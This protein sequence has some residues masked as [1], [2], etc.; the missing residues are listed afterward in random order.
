LSHIKTT[1]NLDD[2]L[3][4]R[5]K[6]LA[7]ERGTT[8]TAVVEAALRAELAGSAKRPPFVLHLPTERGDRPPVVDPADRH[9]LYDLMATDGAKR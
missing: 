1:L 2:E 5:S 8:L 3:M 4:R 6:R 7:A 9:A